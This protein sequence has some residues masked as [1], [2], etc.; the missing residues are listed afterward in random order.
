M[1]TRRRAPFLSIVLVALLPTGSFGA[2]SAQT[3]SPADQ[4]IHQVRLL[5]RDQPTIAVLPLVGDR[6]DDAGVLIPLV[7]STVTGL[8]AR[9]YRVISAVEPAT[10][11]AVSS[12]VGR[13]PVG[14]A[15]LGRFSSSVGAG[16]L[17]VF[18]AALAEYARANEMTVTTSVYQS[19]RAGL[20]DVWRSTSAYR[21][22]ATQ[23]STAEVAECS[24]NLLVNA[25]FDR[26]WDTAWTRNFGD[27]NAGGAVT[28]VVRDNGRTLLHL[29]YQGTS[30]VTLS[31]VV[32]V[33]RGRVWL[34]FDGAVTAREGPIV[35]FTG[36]GQGGITV[37]LLDGRR[38]PIGQ[39]WIGSLVV[40][41]FEDTGL[42]GVPKS[43]RNSANLA[44]YQIPNETWTNQTIDVSKYIRDRIGNADIG[45]VEYVLVSVSAGATHPSASADVWIDSLEVRVC[46][47]TASPVGRPTLKRRP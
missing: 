4:V 46:P 35:G 3:E 16:L 21:V 27:V 36:T 39:M 11:R 18:A 1:R 8:R 5:A 47:S 30:F 19:G 33:P 12:S 44:V 31:Q 9:G 7:N 6:Y 25:T 40:N 38:E 43:P 42:A 17:I 45:R 23:S 13:S 24:D 29:Q 15:S 2:L 10:A 28:E 14:R 34:T 37:I 22:A 32:K 41:P 26:D 20:T